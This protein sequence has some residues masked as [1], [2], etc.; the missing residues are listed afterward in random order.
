MCP[1][2]LCSA[3]LNQSSL[4]AALLVL[5]RH[6]QDLCITKRDDLLGRWVDGKIS[7]TS[8]DTAIISVLFPL[9][10]GQ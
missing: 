7:D 5:L 2:A 10:K 6:I 4:S 1:P 9:P 3:F 8:T